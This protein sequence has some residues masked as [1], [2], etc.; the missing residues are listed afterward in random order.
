MSP[1]VASC[2]CPHP[3]LLIPD[4]GGK[5]LKKVEST[6]MGM[7]NLAKELKELQA[8]VFIYISPHSTLYADA[9]AVRN[10]A[11]LKGSF[12]NFGCGNI[13]FEERNDLET[14]N[15]IFEI[16]EKHEL[17][18]VKLKDGRGGWLHP[19]EDLDHGILVPLYYIESE[20]GD[21]PI[22]C[23]SISAMDYEEHKKFGKCIYEAVEELGKRA[24]FVASGDLSHRLTPSAPSGFSKTGRILDERIV[25]VLRTGNFEDLFGIDE[26]LVEKAGE[27]GLR[28]IFVM[29]GVLNKK[30]IAS[31]VLSYEGPFGVGYVVSLHRVLN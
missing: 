4:I 16:C 15:R 1:I 28:S 24:V 11:K 25:D 9:F 8:D 7:R 26:T 5:D 27:C 17:P 20:V 23:V 10:K 12:A 22:V 18:A 6:I 13:M 31:E 2:V 19:E 3:P 21:K 14:A 30:E 29:S